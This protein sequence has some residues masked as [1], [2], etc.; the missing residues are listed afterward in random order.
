MV[1]LDEWS[2]CLKVD[3]GRLIDLK[4]IAI[5]GAHQRI[6][7]LFLNSGAVGFPMTGLRAWKM[8]SP[9]ADRTWVFGQFW[10]YPHKFIITFS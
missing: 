1:E 6:K 4:I 7:D 5:D 9:I 2:F 10:F 3:L 8:N